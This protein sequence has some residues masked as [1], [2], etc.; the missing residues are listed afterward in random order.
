MLSGNCTN[1]NCTFRTISK[2]STPKQSARS[3]AA[4]SDTPAK[5]KKPPR[6]RR[7]SKCITYNL[8]D[9]EKE[10]AME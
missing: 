6:V 9:I 4:S 1:K 10:E 3:K 8:Y 2:P 5:E 7:S